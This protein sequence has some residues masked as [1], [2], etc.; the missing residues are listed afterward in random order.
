MRGIS[1]LFGLLL[2]IC[3]FVQNVNS[4][5]YHIFRSNDGLHSFGGMKKSFPSLV[6]NLPEVQQDE[7][8]NIVQLK[9]FIPESV[10]HRR[11][12]WSLKVLLKFFKNPLT[13][14]AASLRAIPVATTTTTM[15]RVK[16]LFPFLDHPWV[17]PLLQRL[18]PV[19]RIIVEWVRDNKEKFIFGTKIMVGVYF[20]KLSLCLFFVNNNMINL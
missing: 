15:S 4:R 6:A 18:S 13:K 12:P 19:G 14:N 20:C 7:I 2:T 9:E 16:L 10:L 5:N 3:L 8:Q 17:K 1:V 11:L